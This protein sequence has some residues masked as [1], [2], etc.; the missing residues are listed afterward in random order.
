M[1]IIERVEQAGAAR[2]IE[3]TAELVPV[4]EGRRYPVAARGRQDAVTIGFISG[5]VTAP[6]RRG[7]GYR[8]QQR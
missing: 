1:D 5:V 7:S 3:E 6:E 4:F 8:D 2:S